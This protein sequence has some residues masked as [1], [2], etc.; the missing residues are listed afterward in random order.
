MSEMDQLIDVQ[1]KARRPAFRFD[2]NKA[3]VWLREQATATNS[4]CRLTLDVEKLEEGM[5]FVHV[6][7]RVRPD[8]LI[9]S[10][11]EVEDLIGRFQRKPWL[12]PV[13]FDVETD[14]AGGQLRSFEAF[15]NI[16]A[17]HC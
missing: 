8:G 9:T 13:Q 2:F 11:E 16:S 1:F 3:T 15:I 17:E 14:D 6:T 7:V 12:A 10:E 5:G 4:G